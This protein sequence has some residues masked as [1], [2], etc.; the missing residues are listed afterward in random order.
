LGTKLHRTKFP[1][2]NQPCNLLSPSA[3]NYNT[4]DIPTPYCTALKALIG[5]EQRLNIVALGAA[6]QAAATLT[7]KWPTWSA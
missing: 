1:G 6:R 2:G 3:V 7:C 5:I 4:G